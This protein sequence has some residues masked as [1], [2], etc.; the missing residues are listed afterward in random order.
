MK[1]Q[2][3]KT[4]DDFISLTNLSGKIYHSSEKELKASLKRTRAFLKYLK[5][6]DKKLKFVHITGTS[7]KGSV[8]SMIHKILHTSGQNVAT[9]VSPHTS[10]YLERFHYNDQLVDA[11]TLNRSMLEVINAYERFLKKGSPLSF[12][13]LSTCLSIYTFARIGAKW[14]VL[15]AGCG[16]RWDATNVID[17]PELAIITNINKDHTEILGD[18]L[19]QIAKEKAGIMKKKGVVL[20]G[21]T[22]PSLKKIFTEEAIKCNAALFFVPPPQKVDFD[23]DKGSAQQHNA[24]IALN[25][26]KE[27]NIDKELAHRALSQYKALPCRFETIQTEPTVILDGA[28]SPAKIKATVERIKHFDKRVHVIFGCKA[29]KNIKEMI[30]QLIPISSSIT[31]T[32]F[33]EIFAKAANPN[34]LLERIPRKRRGGSFLFPDDALE[35]AL[36]RAKPSDIILVTGSLYLTGELRKKWIPEDT[37]INHGNSFP[38]YTVKFA[39]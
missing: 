31:T 22:R 20:C 6:P 37:I 3:Y 8:A 36:K 25:A 34:D 4:Y 21:E 17:T 14:C 2:I 19:A 28:H 18:S 35:Y 11:D 13:E 23:K 38:K 5:N 15:E 9:Y 12:F 27:L 30:D 29:S 10:T 32:R 33:T 24:A 1:H 16:G 7:G 26:A 39:R